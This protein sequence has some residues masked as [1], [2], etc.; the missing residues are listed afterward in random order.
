MGEGG[1]LGVYY[2]I[3]MTMLIL[4]FLKEKKNLDVIISQTTL[5]STCVTGPRTLDT[6]RAMLVYHNMYA[7]PSFCHIILVM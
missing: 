5:Y 4:S 2:H 3:H 1:Y 6:N 7:E